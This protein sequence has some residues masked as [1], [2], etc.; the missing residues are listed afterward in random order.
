MLLCTPLV[1]A[2]ADQSFSSL[3][4]KVMRAHTLSIAQGLA[5][6]HRMNYVHLDVKPSN[7]ML[8]ENSMGA[9]EAK[10]I[11]FGLAE[12]RNSRYALHSARS[13]R[14]FFSTTTASGT[15]EYF[16]PETVLAE[17]QG[18]P[19]PTTI[20]QDAWSFGVTLIS[21]LCGQNPF[22][23]QDNTSC[24]IKKGHATAEAAL[25]ARDLSPAL[26]N[27]LHGLLHIDPLKRLVPATVLS[28][29]WARIGSAASSQ[30][31]ACAERRRWLVGVPQ[32]FEL[33]SAHCWEK[34]R[35]VSKQ[36]RALVPFALARLPLAMPF[37]SLS[38][39]A[40][41]V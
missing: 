10:L 21:A 23:Q 41:V 33:Q 11:D 25:R 15:P 32:R 19:Q 39:M 30:T 38:S 8:C 40:C 6:L 7:I 34:R 5:A 22:S 35:V 31:L 9:V 28:H 20:A 1:H 17:E 2:L 29:P 26:R 3:L 27:L 18:Q 16:A 13:S 12:K 14:Q 4:P 36:A 24:A 37:G